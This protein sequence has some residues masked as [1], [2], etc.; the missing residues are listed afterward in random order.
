M[1]QDPAERVNLAASQPDVLA[2]MT[3]KHGGGEYKAYVH[4]EMNAYDM[5]PYEC[6]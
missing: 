5:L 6:W 4:G 1:E 2:A 3:A